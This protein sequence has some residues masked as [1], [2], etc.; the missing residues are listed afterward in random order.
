M[1]YNR[2][3]HQHFIRDGFVKIGHKSPPFYE[4]IS[5]DLRT[6]CTQVISD[7]VTNENAKSVVLA[8]SLGVKDELDN[9][10][11]R[12]FSATGA[13]HVLAVSG[14]HV[15]IIYLIL[16]QLFQKVGLSKK[17][18]RWLM[19][20][21]SILILWFYALLTGLS[22]SVLRAVTMFSFV[23]MGRALFRNGNIYNTLAASAFV[24]LWFN[25]YLIMSV[26]FQLSYLAVFGI[27][28]LQPKMYTLWTPNHWLLDKIWAI[29]C[30]SIA[31]QMA[32]GPLSMLY[33]HQFP[34]YFL[35]SNLFIIPAAFVTL[36]GSLLLLLV[37]F[38][39][40]LAGFIGT[41]LSTFV[42]SVN[43]LVFWVSSFPGSTIDGVYLDILQT[44]LIYFALGGMI[45]FFIKKKMNWLYLSLVFCVAQIY[46]FSESAQ[47][48]ELSQLS[49]NNAQVLDMRAGFKSKLI[50]DSAFLDDEEK[51][52]FH[53]HQKR[54]ASGSNHK[55]EKDQLKVPK[56]STPLGQVFTL[57]GKSIL[58]LNKMIPLNKSLAFDFVFI[59]SRDFRFKE[60]HFQ[61]IR[62]EQFIMGND[63]WRNTE[64]DLSVYLTS[65]NLSF[66]SLR[67][68]GYFSSVWRR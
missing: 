67:T 22:P 17:R 10:L 50:A 21:L 48:I 28:Y 54:I 42:W 44:W 1:A 61:H 45:L 49:V 53:L 51:Q 55:I 41:V 33:F 23:A 47:S 64:G 9:D 4:R 24:L 14:L 11:V 63:I 34:T 25:P 58:M 16:F 52:R 59:D 5:D 57:E 27:V 35:V 43:Q 60:S 56:A 65:K 15:G 20:G 26:G 66:H 39:P 12:A 36:I 32:T 68:E 19:A 7:R 3:Y 13:M 18:Y 40:I 2:I 30:V 6:Y 31:A 62:A 38:V 46:H 37:S 29:S 8:L